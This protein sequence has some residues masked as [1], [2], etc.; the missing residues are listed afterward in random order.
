M[1]ILQ[2][3]GA[4]VPVLIQPATPMRE[5][6][7]IKLM[8]FYHLITFATDARVVRKF[9]LLHPLSEV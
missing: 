4:T 8:R 6:D 3:R 9:V 5:Q 2:D 1:K 7:T